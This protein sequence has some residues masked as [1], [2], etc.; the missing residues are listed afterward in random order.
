MKRARCGQGGACHRLT[1]SDCR[2][3]V[4][5]TLLELLTVS[6]LIFALTALALPA[7]RQ[8]RERALAAGCTGGLRQIGVVL[9]GYSVDYD[10]FAMPALF[11]QNA[12]DST[13]DSWLNYVTGYTR[14]PAIG[15][16]PGMPIAACFN[17][18]G[19]NCPPW[20]G[21]TAGSYVM[22][23]IRAGAWAGSDLPSPPVQATGWGDGTR[24]P[25]RF[26]RARRPAGSIVVTDALEGISAFDAQGIVAFQE[27]DRGNAIDRDVGWLHDDGFNALMGDGHVEARQMTRAEEWAV[28]P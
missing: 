24:H 26:V 18:Y 21:V 7:L 27:T 9:H 5:F 19:G 15:R 14:T 25:I 6:T 4:R 17:P 13:I 1:G 23:V 16:C 3:C 28:A 20:D 8:A 10:G 2:S 12:T 22:N 11:G